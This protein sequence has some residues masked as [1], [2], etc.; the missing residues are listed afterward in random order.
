MQEVRHGLWPFLMVCLLVAWPCCQGL[1][2]ASLGVGC[3]S[4]SEYL[5]VADTTGYRIAGCYRK[6]DGNENGGPLYI[7]TD[8]GAVD[9]GKGRATAV[10]PRDVSREEVLRKVGALHGTICSVPGRATEE[11]ALGCG[12][13]CSYWSLEMVIVGVGLQVRNTAASSSA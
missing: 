11:Y 3:N 1:T 13:G 7:N 8:G 4:N 6:T 12:L 10:W 5:T 2:A 9:G